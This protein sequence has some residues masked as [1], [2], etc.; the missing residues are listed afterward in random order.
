MNDFLSNQF[1]CVASILVI[2]DV[3]VASDMFKC[4]GT[5]LSPLQKQKKD[6]Q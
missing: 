2:H 6:V 5:A 3:I 1:V 4:I